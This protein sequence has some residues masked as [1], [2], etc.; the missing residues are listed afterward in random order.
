MGVVYKARQTSANRLVALKLIRD[1]ALAVAARACPVPSR[2]RSR[3]S[4][5]ASQHRRRST[6]SGEY[7]GQPYFA[8]ELVEGGTL[9]K[10]LTGQPLPASLAA[11]LIRA[12]AL[13]IQH[14]HEQRVVHRDLKPA[15]ILLSVD[16]GQWAV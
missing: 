10:H 9:D 16:S 6:R 12:L 2:S 13:A 14:A 15:N 1:G 8:M 11:E 7:Q 5:E 3:G 4:D